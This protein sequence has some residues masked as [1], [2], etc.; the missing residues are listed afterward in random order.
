MNPD[1]ALFTW[2]NKTEVK[3]GSTTCGF[4]T[5]P[6]DMTD[7]ASPKNK[8]KVYFC[9][10]FADT[11]PAKKGTIFTHCGGPGT[12]SECGI[13]IALNYFPEL[14]KDYNFV[15]VDQRG[16]GRSTP[17]FFHLEECAYLKRDPSFNPIRDAQG[18]MMPDWH[19]LADPEN[20]DS[21]RTYLRQQANRL[22]SCW[23][24]PAFN[25]VAGAKSY[26][27]LQYSGTKQLVEDLFLFRKAI[28]APKL[29][30]NGISYGTQ[31]AATYA[32]TFPEYVDKLVLDS[33]FPPH[34]DLYDI[35]YG[36]AQG[37]DQQWNFIAYSCT[38][39]NARKP[40]SCPV[41]NAGVCIE[42]V[43]SRVSVLNKENKINFGPSQLLQT[44]GFAVQRQAVNIGAVNKLLTTFKPF[45]DLW[46]AN[47][48]AK[49]DQA[50]IEESKPAE[51]MTTLPNN[52][53][54]Q[55]SLI[56]TYSKPTS[57]EV[58]EQIYMH[59]N[60]FTTGNLGVAAQTF[61]L[62]QDC[63]GISYNENS[64][65]ASWKPALEK[66]PALQTGLAAELFVWWWHLGYF[67]PKSTPI[68][69]MG[70]PNVTGIVG[71]NIFDPNTPYIWTQK[72]ASFFPNCRQVST[73]NVVHGIIKTPACKKVVLDYFNDGKLPTTGHTCGAPLPTFV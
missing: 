38:A 64:F 52:R 46:D 49:L 20:E 51:P 2:I 10:R 28:G 68:A 6:L 59:Y 16:L 34:A 40:G 70:N 73:Q 67:W 27:F 14:A 35:G 30:I 33:N 39:Q 56:T 45:C 1:P 5:P 63:T 25:I 43:L 23:R 65:I 44:M 57:F 9:M 50:I 22:P 3:E 37:A 15:G 36:T 48:L 42:A 32:T 41:S 53:R 11:Q 54:M 12:L 18:N 29:S 71:G 55:P 62:A 58:M 31:V 66:Y 47:E 7:P 17:S 60:D 19:I 69:S 8:V 21:V 72:M 26:H 13:N 61:I 4:L 24:T